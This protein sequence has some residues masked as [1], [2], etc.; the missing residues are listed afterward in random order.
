MKVNYWADTYGYD[1]DSRSGE[2]IYRACLEIGLKLRAMIGDQNI[3]KL[4][5]LF[6]DY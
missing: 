6:Q 3:T 1:K 4:R 2:K 5:D